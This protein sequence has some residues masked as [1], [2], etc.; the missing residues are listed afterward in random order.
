MVIGMAT[1][2]VT[3]TLEETQLE[4]IRALV[5]EGRARNVSAFV[6]HAVDNSLADIVEWE[7]MIDDALNET[8]GPPTPEEV[9][10]AEE[11]IGVKPPKRRSQGAA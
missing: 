6:Q 3:I 2:K 10:W 1:V 9:A 7:Q 4:Q 11:A 5:R 8:G